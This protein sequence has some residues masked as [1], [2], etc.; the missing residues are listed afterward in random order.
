MEIKKIETYE[1]DGKYFKYK[2]EALEYMNQ[3]EKINE[4]N[5][6]TPKNVISHFYNNQEEFKKLYDKVLNSSYENLA[7]NVDKI[8]EAIKENKTEIAF[9]FNSSHFYNEV[10]NQLREPMA[11]KYAKDTITD[12][13]LSD[14]K[15]SRIYSKIKE[16]WVSNILS[17][18]DEIDDFL[19]FIELLDS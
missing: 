19:D 10:F 17:A 18:Q 13:K 5:L 4:V 12:I 6:D 2:K 7:K 3:K 16:K 9:Y 8:V 11:I 1:V 14:A 15:I